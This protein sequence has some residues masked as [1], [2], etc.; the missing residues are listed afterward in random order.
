MI[1]KSLLSSFV[2]TYVLFPQHVLTLRRIEPTLGVDEF[3]SANKGGDLNEVYVFVHIPK[4]AG[5]SFLQCLRSV[6]TDKWSHIFPHEGNSWNS[7]GCAKPAYGGT[8]CSIGEMEDCFNGGFA[9]LQE[10]YA[11]K[12]NMLKRKYFTII[13]H[14][15][16]RVLSEYAWWLKHGP[17]PEQL[18]ADQ[19][20]GGLLAWVRSPFNVAH[21][22][23][24]KHLTGTGAQAPVKFN[25]INCM[26]FDMKDYLTYWSNRYNGSKWE[27]GLEQK[28]NKDNSLLQKAISNLW[29]VGAQ[30]DLQTSAMLFA[31]KLDSS[32]KD[33]KF[34]ECQKRSH[35]SQAAPAETISSEIID[36]IASRNALDIALYNKYFVNTDNLVEKIP[37][38]ES[39]TW[40]DVLDDDY[41]DDIDFG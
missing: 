27:D 23:A 14:P 15:V 37:M 38:Y 34:A 20:R 35:Q 10:P 25:K 11:R 26:T 33:V 12:P 3:P 9:D 17:W 36:E 16:K 5:S 31:K 32:A 39:L 30:E 24:V 13:R 2:A 19:R 8:H 22:R 40:S 4:C 29:F 1:H 28:L 41:G 7:K 6:G 18:R 21:N